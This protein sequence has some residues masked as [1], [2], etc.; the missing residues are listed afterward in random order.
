MSVIAN[1][2]V[3]SNFASIDQLELLRRLFGSVYI[4]TEVYREI[5][6]GLD[7]GYRFYG[8]LIRMMH[9]TSS[10]NWLQLTSAA[11]ELELRTLNSLPTSLHP[12][13]AS[14][15]A[16]AQTRGWYFLSDDLAARNYAT[17]A[18]I[19]LS[20]SIGCLVLA[21]ERG[22]CPLE[23]ANSL[24]DQ[25]IQQGFRSPLNDVGPILRQP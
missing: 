2:T 21:V 16:I 7:E 4:S 12:G 15:L 11:S 1:T 8:T 22:L 6:D 3:I 10:E 14:S 24:L 23:F 13:E 5:Q 17:R 19:N 18:G 20:G 25:M 9:S